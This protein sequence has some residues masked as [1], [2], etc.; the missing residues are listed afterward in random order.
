MAVLRNLKHELAAQLLAEDRQT[1]QQIA[2]AVG[3]T[4]R[5]IGYWKCRPEIEARISEICDLAATR[6]QNHSERREWLWERDCLRREAS[7]SKNS[8]ARRVAVQML[9]EMGAL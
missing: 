3:V 5:T 6:L 4:R 8:I 1:D 7:T 2:A 9:Q